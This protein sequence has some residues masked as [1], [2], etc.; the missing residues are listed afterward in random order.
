MALGLA[1]TTCRGVGGFTTDYCTNLFSAR[2]C[3]SLWGNDKCCRLHFCL[4]YVSSSYSATTCTRYSDTKCCSTEYV[5]GQDSCCNQ[6]QFDYTSSSINRY[7]TPSSRGSTIIGGIVGGAVGG[8]AFL[9]LIIVIPIVACGAC[10]VR[11]SGGTITTVRIASNQVQPQ[12]YNQS[13]GHQPF[14]LG[15]HQPS[16]QGYAEPPQSHPPQGSSQGYEQA[17][18]GMVAPAYLPK[19]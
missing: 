9:I 4:P 5:G 12:H 6:R 14:M 19:Y 16:M 13:P 7:G 15:H 3:S 18:P 1:W 2:C 10:S 17:Q 11:K 8:V